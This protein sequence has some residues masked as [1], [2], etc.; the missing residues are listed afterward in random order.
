MTKCTPLQPGNQ[1]LTGLEPGDLTAE[2][3]QPGD[4][5]DVCP[6][7][8]ILTM[9]GSSRIY[10]P[11]DPQPNNASMHYELQS[12]GNVFAVLNP[13]EGAGPPSFVQEQTLT[14]WIR[15]IIA[16]AGPGVYHGRMVQNSGDPLSAQSDALNT[17]IDLVT[18][19]GFIFG[20]EGQGVITLN[21]NMTCSLSDDGGATVIDSASV[22]L[23]L[24]IQP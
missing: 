5:I 20:L 16:A 7:G 15:P 17:W 2:S 13:D 18:G 1:I 23:Q 10:A 14:D 6:P 19:G 22:I 11:T 12:N 9:S 4:N 21:A 8:V 24:A 3:T